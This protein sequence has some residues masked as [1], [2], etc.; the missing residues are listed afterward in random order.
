LKVAHNSA[1]IIL[2]GSSIGIGILSP[3]HLI[4]R[5]RK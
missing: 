5:N 1:Q 4:P 3:L 2:L